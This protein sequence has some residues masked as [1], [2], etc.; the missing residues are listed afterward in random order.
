[1][2]GLIRKINQ[3][4]NNIFNHDQKYLY[5]VKLKKVNDSY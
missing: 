4:L 3:L 1:M 5:L 2:S